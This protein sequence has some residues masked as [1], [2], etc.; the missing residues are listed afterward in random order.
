M[1]KCVQP[2][3]DKMATVLV[4]WPGDGPKGMCKE[5]AKKAVAVGQAIGCHIVTSQLLNI[6]ESE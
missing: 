5:C 2:K 4:F 3:C 1:N 6:Y